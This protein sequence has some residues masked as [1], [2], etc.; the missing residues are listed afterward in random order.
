MVRDDYLLRAI[1]QALTLLPYIRRMV[2]EQRDGAALDLI[3]QTVRRVLG[4]PPD[5]LTFSLRDVLPYLRGTV[6]TALDGEQRLAVAALLREAGTI[7]ALQQRQE[8]AYA[9][10][11]QALAVLLATP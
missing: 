8:A 3:A 6:L 4:V 9:C 1:R 11:L 7:H 5:D 2:Q 10:H